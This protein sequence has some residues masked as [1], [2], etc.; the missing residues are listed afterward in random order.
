MTGIYGP[1]GSGKT[2]LLRAIAGLEP[3][4]IGSIS[5]LETEYLSSTSELAIHQ[6]QIGMVFQDA[7]LFPH[8]SVEENLLYGRERLDNPPKIKDLEIML[9]LILLILIHMKV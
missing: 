9:P 5:I 1:S 7:N 6:R 8:L 3:D 4:T 2:S